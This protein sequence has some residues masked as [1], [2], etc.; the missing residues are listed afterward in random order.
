MGQVITHKITVRTLA[1]L[2]RAYIDKLHEVHRLKEV[3]KQEGISKRETPFISQNEVS[4]SLAKAD[5]GKRECFLARNGRAIKDTN[6]TDILY[7][8]YIRSFVYEGYKYISKRGVKTKEF[9][10]YV[11]QDYVHISN[12]KEV[13]SEGVFNISNFIPAAIGDSVFV[14]NNPKRYKFINDGKIY[15]SFEDVL[16][17]IHTENKNLCE[18]GTAF[19]K[20]H[21]DA[22]GIDNSTITEIATYIC[23]IGEAATKEYNSY[24]YGKLNGYERSLYDEPY[25]PVDKKYYL[26]YLYGLQLNLKN[27]SD[28]ESEILTLTIHQPARMR[29]I[30]YRLR[31]QE[32]KKLSFKHK[33]HMLHVLVTGMATGF[34]G[35]MGEARIMK[36]I[37]AIKPEEEADFLLELTRSNLINKLIYRLDGSKFADLSFAI[38]E[39]IFRNRNVPTLKDLDADDA[40]KIRPEGYENKKNLGFNNHSKNKERYYHSQ[41]RINSGGFRISWDNGAWF[42]KKQNRNYNTI[43]FD[44]FVVLNIG[45]DGLK[46][47]GIEGSEK[48]VIPGILLHWI[49][50]QQDNEEAWKKVRITVE[51]IFTLLSLGEYA[52]ARTAIAAAI[53]V[54]DIAVG[55]T[56]I[57]IEVSDLRKNKEFKQFIGIWDK[58]LLVYGI[59]RGLSLLW[60]IS[61]KRLEQFKKSFEKYKDKIKPKFRKEVQAKLNSKFDDGLNSKNSDD[62]LKNENFDTLSKEAQDEIRAMRQN[63]RWSNTN[64]GPKEG[65]KPSK[66]TIATGSVQMELHPNYNKLINEVE[67]LGYEVVIVKQ[68]FSKIQIDPHVEV[69]GVT[70]KNG[71]VTYKK[72]IFLLEKMDY[73]TLVHEYGHVLQVEKLQKE[74]INLVTHRGFI[75]ENSGKLVIKDVGGNQ[76]MWDA[77]EYHN[78][79]QDLVRLRNLQKAKV[80]VPPNMI[81]QAE[82]A[83]KN[84]KKETFKGVSGKFGYKKTDKLK[85]QLGSIYGEIRKLEQMIK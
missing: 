58:F 35:N 11:R 33:V 34:F 76:R 21:K 74:G 13:P 19:Y 69:I 75:R 49:L 79:L 64:Y 20:L 9:V 85:S 32:I 70:T 37:N 30:V 1:D 2:E 54:T 22:K 77:I 71:A 63:E 18:A 39:M 40:P 45:K 38:T 60:K 78:R 27:F 59:G 48:I 61:P 26:D 4:N 50:K 7:D 12:L 56:S 23:R 84:Y 57:F 15:T 44:E 31:F 5:G 66:Q 25:L 55:V 43:Q 47:L 24:A 51:V 81:K 29:D 68:D 80:D 82:A 83:V 10:G 52:A 17:K 28:I 53:A 67:D 36:V 6:I 42:D 14:Y 3:E 62:L 65:L 16:H 41:N 8:L 46:Y 72:K 73:D